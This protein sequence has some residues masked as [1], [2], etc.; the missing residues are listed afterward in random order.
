V[1]IELEEVEVVAEEVEDGLALAEVAAANK[2][3]LHRP[4]ARQQQLVTTQRLQQRHQS[5]L[6]SW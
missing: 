1:E 3:T 2:H 5:S 6:L 4:P